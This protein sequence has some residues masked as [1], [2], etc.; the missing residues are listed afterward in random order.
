MEPETHNAIVIG[1]GGLGREVAS[2]I[3]T[4]FPNQYTLLGF[5]DDGVEANTTVNGI[6]VLGGVEYLAEYSQSVCIFMGIGIPR[7]R[8]LIFDKIK[9]NQNLSFPNLIHPYARIHNPETVQFGMGNIVSDG[10]IIT[11]NV[12]I[13]N[14]NLL[15][16]TTTIGHDA[17]IGDFCSI[18]PAVNISGGAKIGDLVY[19]GTGAKLINATSI[20]TQSTSTLR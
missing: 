12:P 3:Q 4:Y 10:V 16:L 1:A 18:M 2:V 11:T 5:V 14:F 7:I 6:K 19:I 13:G 17:S 20:G 15:N 9:A 8:K